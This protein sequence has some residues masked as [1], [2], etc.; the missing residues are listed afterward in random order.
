MAGALNI[1]IDISASTGVRRGADVIRYLLAGANTVQVCSVLYEKGISHLKEMNAELA[2]WMTKNDFK[3]ISDFRGRLN[4]ENIEKPSIFERS[5]FI[6][7][8][9]SQDNKLVNQLL[10]LLG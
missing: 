1:K 10:F 4:Y 3:G 7:Y 9:S 2:E 6:I 5:Q 8:F